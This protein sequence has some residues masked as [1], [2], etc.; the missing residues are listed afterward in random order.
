MPWDL[1]LTT[2]PVDARPSRSCQ[3]GAQTESARSRGAAHV[4][5]RGLRETWGAVRLRGVDAGNWLAWSGRRDDPGAPRYLQ[6]AHPGEE[7]LSEE[8][9]A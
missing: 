2:V 7:Q 9:C 4:G 1:A 3:D 8:P 5:G 6:R